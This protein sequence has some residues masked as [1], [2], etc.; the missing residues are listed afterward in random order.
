MK[1]TINVVCLNH[2][3]DQSPTPA[4]S[5]EKLSSTKLVPAAKKFGDCW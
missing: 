4:Q 2:S 5:M 1:Y 3:K